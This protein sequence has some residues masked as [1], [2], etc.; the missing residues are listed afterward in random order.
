MQNS[1]S[2]DV[3]T[4][5]D[6]PARDEA[7]DEGREE[8][9]TADEVTIPCRSVEVS[10]C[11]EAPFNIEEPFITQAPFIS[12]TGFMDINTRRRLPGDALIS[13]PAP[14]RFAWQTHT[15]GTPFRTAGSGI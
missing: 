8:T 11:G 4:G 1:L 13:R 14:H 5:T 9:C 2:A 10:S 15:Q 6:T 12:P 7:W 3:L